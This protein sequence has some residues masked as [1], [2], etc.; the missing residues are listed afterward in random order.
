MY[1]KFTTFL[2]IALLLITSALPVMAAEGEQ[3]HIVPDLSKEGAI[4]VNVRDTDTKKAVSG[5]K[6]AIYKVA[7]AKENDGDYTFEYCDEFKGL[8]TPLDNLENA[9]L[10]NTFS[11]Y[12]K[13]NNITGTEMVVNEAGQAE[14]SR[15]AC[16]I[17]LIVQ[18]ESATDYTALSPFIVSIP[19]LEGDEYI[20][21]VDAS[22]KTGTVAKNPTKPDKP[23][24]PDERIPQTGQIWWPVSVLALAGLLLVILGMKLRS[25]N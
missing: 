25:D 24:T 11:D 14:F 19:L 4:T 9:E 2:L 1:Q 13:V 10:A 18:I 3:K 6:L 5:G 15:L 16:G 7:V 21:D 12:V 23:T 20:Y 8:K 22:P 17:Y